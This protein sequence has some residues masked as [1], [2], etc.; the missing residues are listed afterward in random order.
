MLL[1]CYLLISKSRP[2]AGL[3]AGGGSKQTGQQVLRTGVGGRLKQVAR[4]RLSRT[5][6]SA[7]MVMMP[8]ETGFFEILRRRDLPAILRVLELGCQVAQL[9]GFGGVAIAACRLRG[10]VKIAGD[11]GHQL[12]EL[13]W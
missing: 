13:A 4:T 10:L 8:G 2:S 11:G 6:V 7:A 12:V 3:R 5:V 9:R 1:P